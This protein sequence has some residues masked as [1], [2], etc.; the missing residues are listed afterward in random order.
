MFNKYVQ[1]KKF[2]KSMFLPR[3]II[4]YLKN[5]ETVSLIIVH[6]YKYIFHAKWILYLRK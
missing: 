2:L 1:N 3:M 6:T 4:L 5:L